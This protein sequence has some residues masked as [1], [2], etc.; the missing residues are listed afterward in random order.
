MSPVLSASA[1]T[2]PQVRRGATPT[3]LIVKG[4]PPTPPPNRDRSRSPAARN[5]PLTL[6][7]RTGSGN[8]ANRQQTPQQNK[9]L[10]QSVY[11][12]EKNRIL[13]DMEDDDPHSGGEF[14]NLWNIVQV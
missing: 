2:L 8:S 11:Q 13:A 14:E 4:K 5:S 10:N 12:Q 6:V 1:F 3:G 9:S 7:R